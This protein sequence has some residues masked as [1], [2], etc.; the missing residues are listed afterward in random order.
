M[1]RMINNSDNATAT[2]LFHFGGGCSTLKLFNLLIP[3][4]DTQ[5]GCESDTY[6]GWGNT[7]TTAVDQLKLMKLYAYDNSVSKTFGAGNQKRALKKCKRLNQS[8]KRKACARTAKRKFGALAKRPI[9]GEDARAYGN[10]LMQGAEPDQRF[11]ITCGPWGTTCDAPNWAVPDPDV[12]VRVKNG[13]KTLPTCTDPI[14][15]CPWQVNSNGWVKGK[16]RDYAMS[17]LTT[18][19]PVGTGDTYGFNYGIETIQGISKLVW[20]NLGS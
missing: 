19:D 15:L 4:N 1:A 5:V 20:S 9:L 17:I 12:T 16:G 10:S 8:A 11:G 6:Y 2:A 14:P 13:W 7:Q 3:M 18:K